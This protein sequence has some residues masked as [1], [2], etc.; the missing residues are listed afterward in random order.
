MTDL[1]NAIFKED[2]A[3]NINSFRQNLQIE[4]TKKLIS[5]VVGARS[6]TYISNAQSMAIYNLKQ[7]K[8]MATVK[9]GNISSKAHKE[10]LTTLINNALKEIK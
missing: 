5:I 8:K 6:K 4:Y 3:G 7:I 9:S 1:N 2:I 10:H